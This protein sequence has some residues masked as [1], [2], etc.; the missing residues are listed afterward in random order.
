MGLLDNV[1]GKV[2]EI[3]SAVQQGSDH[4][5]LMGHVTDFVHSHPGGL[6]GLVQTLREKGLGDVVNSWISREHN[7]P[8][9]AAQIDSA[10][11]NEKIQALATKLGVPT[12]TISSGLATILPQVVDKLTPN[13]A[14]P[15]A[16]ASVPLTPPAPAPPQA[17]A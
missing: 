12:S 14:V 11:G 4:P 6:Q 3:E 1:T 8:V 7:Q 10:L 13:G 9:T 2:N 17:T 16:A 5:G 15:A